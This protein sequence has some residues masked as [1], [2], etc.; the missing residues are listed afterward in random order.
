MP[1]A[2]LK[3]ASDAVATGFVF[4]HGFGFESSVGPPV[5]NTELEDGAAPDVQDLLGD[6]RTVRIVATVEPQFDG[7]KPRSETT[8]TG[9]FNAAPLAVEAG[10]SSRR[11]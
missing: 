11:N 10:H 3:D 4:G 1:L 7:G 8:T 5:L 2:L 9:Q 6:D